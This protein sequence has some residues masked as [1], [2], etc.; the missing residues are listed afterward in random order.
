MLAQ[1]V[2]SHRWTTAEVPPLPPIQPTFPF[3]LSFNFGLQK[4]TFLGAKTTWFSFGHRK[5]SNPQPG[6]WFSP[7]SGPGLQAD[8]ITRYNSRFP[9]Q[10]F[11]AF[12]ALPNVIPSFL[13]C[14]S[15][16]FSPIHIL[17]S[18][19]SSGPTSSKYSRW[20]STV[21]PFHPMY[22]SVITLSFWN[23]LSAQ[24]STPPANT[25][26]K[27]ESVSS[28]SKIKYNW[29]KIC[30]LLKQTGVH[31]CIPYLDSSSSPEFIQKAENFMVFAC[32]AL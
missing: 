1:A 19:F 25:V 8:L 16:C 15:L 23:C 27:G 28:L 22:L 11:R 26:L 21:I 6:I 20:H 12:F 14:P 32:F 3:N 7:W 4:S 5:N 2:A 29:S 17:P 30:C 9:H 24:R 10:P 13:E 18:K 31:C